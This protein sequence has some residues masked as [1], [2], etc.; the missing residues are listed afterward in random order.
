MQTKFTLGTVVPLDPQSIYFERAA[1]HTVLGAW[2]EGVGAYLYGPSR[3]GKTS[4]LKRQLDLAERRG[5]GTGYFDLLGFTLAEFLADLG[6]VLGFEAPT[7]Q[8]P[9]ETLEAIVAA[10]ASREAP[11]LLAFDELP[12]ATELRDAMRVV[13]NAARRSHGR[14]RVLVAEVAV[15]PG[16]P[17]LPA[18][19]LEEC[20][21]ELLLQLGD[22]VALAMLPPE[23]GPEY[24]AHIAREVAQQ[25]FEWTAGVPYH[26]QILA[27]A[28]ATDFPLR[29]SREDIRTAL[30]RIVASWEH[31]GHEAFRVDSRRLPTDDIPRLD[32][33]TR[34]VELL[35]RWPGASLL[36]LDAAVSL[37]PYAIEG[38]VS[39]ADRP[40]GVVARVRSRL[41][42][43]LHRGTARAMLMQEQ[44]SYTQEL[45]RWVES[46][47]SPTELPAHRRRAAILEELERTPSLSASDRE[48]QTAIQTA[49]K[50]DET[51]QRASRIRRTAMGVGVAA[52]IVGAVGVAWGAE[53]DR[54]RAEADR[55]RAEAEYQRAQA[56]RERDDAIREL[57]ARRQLSQQLGSNSLPS[58]LP[59]EDY[60]RLVEG[61]LSE[62]FLPS[63]DVSI[64][65]L[66]SDLSAARERLNRARA[67]LLLF[68]RHLARVGTAEA[69]L[70]RC[71]NTASQ[72]N[73]T[74]DEQLSQLRRAHELSATSLGQCQ[75]DSDAA[76][77]FRQRCEED[78]RRARSEFAAPAAGQEHD[79]AELL[80]GLEVTETAL[81]TCQGELR[82]AQTDRTE[83]DRCRT[84]TAELEQG[85]RTASE[86]LHACQRAR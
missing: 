74:H 64:E 73:A 72:A 54:A 13:V 8:A 60:R 82:V 77:A 58:N 49:A 70:T 75:R 45:V 47:R 1:D 9:H 20:S 29:H 44:R 22:A 11:Y 86:A 68:D 2:T 63:G 4:L 53:A 18:V 19:N 71:R 17:D 55:E 3:Q 35:A 40:S 50:E 61:W 12:P 5:W 31:D 85:L 37:E 15:R 59:L 32:L 39:L 24:R 52:I 42:R 51:S 41:V 10:L 21:P 23:A 84:T 66:A 48:F 81:R 36:T 56:E 25:I 62:E 33:L 79:P 7:H 28:L 6:M 69:E 34:Y 78:L 46:G 76:T 26:A 80:R 43:T 14:V 38:Y 30:E 16:F 67:L 27:H 83:L 57:R 65:A